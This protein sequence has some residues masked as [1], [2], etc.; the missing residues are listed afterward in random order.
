M[1][2]RRTR[3]DLLELT[4]YQLQDIGLTRLDAINEGRRPFW[5]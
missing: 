1:E 3:R 2:R 5:H 4:D